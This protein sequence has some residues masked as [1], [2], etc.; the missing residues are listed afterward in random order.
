MATTTVN[1]DQTADTITCAT[2]S[3]AD[4]SWR[5]S[6][7]ID[8]GTDKFLDAMLGGKVTTGTS[9]TANTNIYIYAY[10]TWDG[11]TTFTGGISGT[12]ATW[13]TNASPDTNEGIV[14]KRLLETIQVTADS[15]EAYD[16]GPV[17]VASAFGGVLPDHW[18]IV[19]RNETGVAFNATAGNHA[20]KF[21]GVKYDTA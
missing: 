11:G 14:A 2:A 3:L 9:P 17:S 8:N 15:D 21:Q 5:A 1:I 6:T 16:F 4:G 7:S 19:V 13:S 12:D 18:G 20:Y 10:G